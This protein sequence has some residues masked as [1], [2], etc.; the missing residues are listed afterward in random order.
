MRAYLDA[1]AAVKLIRDERE[2]DALAHFLQRL[3]EPLAVVSSMLVETELRRMAVRDGMP[4]EAVSL[5][6]RKISL[7]ELDR[8]HFRAAGLLPDRSLRS[9]DALH[10]V[11]AMQA[12]ADVLVAYDI[13]LLQAARTVGMRSISPT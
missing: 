12:D 5:A 2:S 1:S 13:R 3:T 7:I 11:S 4:Q 9:L 6:L 8:D 10:L